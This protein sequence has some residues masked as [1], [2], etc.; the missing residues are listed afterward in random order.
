MEKKVIIM[1][2]TVSSLF[3]SVNNVLAG[4]YDDYPNRNV[5]VDS[6]YVQSKINNSNVV[7]VDVRNSIEYKDGHIPGAINIPGDGIR[8]AG[9]TSFMF[10]IDGIDLPESEHDIE[11]YETIFSKAG[12][13]NDKEVIF[14]GSRGGRTDGTAPFIILSMLGHPNVKFLDGNGLY[15]WGS[16]GGNI[17]TNTNILESAIFTSQTSVF[18]EIMVTAEEVLDCMKDDNCIILDTRSY[19]EYAGIQ[20]AGGQRG[21]R[22]GHVP[23]A[24]HINYVE[25]YREKKGPD[26]KL[27]PYANIKELLENNGLTPDMRVIMY[28]WTSTRIGETWIALKASGFNNLGVYDHGITEWNMLPITAYPMT[29]GNPYRIDKLKG[30]IDANKDTANTADKAPE[31]TLGYSMTPM[32]KAD[33]VKT[34][35]KS[36]CGPTA[37]LAI[38]MLIPLI[39]YNRFF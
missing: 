22:G 9:G 1:I 19:E 26:Y 29:P 7:I 37:I 12:I 6:S 8:T 33:A 3:L 5:V 10:H 20:I 27:K 30:I 35:E 11:K 38:A 4:T 24:L 21:L 14:Y 2:V 31:E 34:E 36:V 17:E 23:G 16:I 15:E 39:Y 18:N 25:F 32:K 13:S 28:C